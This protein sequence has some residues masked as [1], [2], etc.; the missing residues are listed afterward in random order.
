M[1]EK[2]IN[3][4]QIAR[5]VFT[6]TTELLGIEPEH[7]LHPN[8]NSLPYIQQQFTQTSSKLNQDNPLRRQQVKENGYPEK[9]FLKLAEKLILI[10]ED[11]TSI[12]GKHFQTA[13]ITEEALR[14]TQRVLY[15]TD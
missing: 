12:T 13:G 7:P 3:L 14:R 10:I 11:K 9:E 6:C 4:N 15:H 1:K 2:K 5:T 8:T